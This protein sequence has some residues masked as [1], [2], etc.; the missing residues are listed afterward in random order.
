MEDAV[1]LGEVSF[2]KEQ[3]ATSINEEEAKKKKRKKETD[4]RWHKSGS[5][6]VFGVRWSPECRKTKPSAALS[7]CREKNAERNG[8]CQRTSAAT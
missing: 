6:S 3:Q 8:S 4:M 7:R 5:S 1:I 2:S